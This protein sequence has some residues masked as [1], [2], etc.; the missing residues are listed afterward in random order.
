[1]DSVFVVHLTDVHLFAEPGGRLGD[2]DTDASLREVLDFLRQDLLQL[3]RQPD[4]ILMTGDLSQ[5]GS[6]QAYA[7]LKEAVLDFRAPLAVLPGNH[8]LHEAF[9]AEWREYEGPWV[10]LG[11]W[12]IVLLDTV[13]PGSDA[14]RLA[15]DQLSLL[16]DAAARS[17]GR[18]VLVA[19]HHNPVTDKL[20]GVDE[21]MLANAQALFS[22]VRRQENVRA[23]LWG[24]VHRPYDQWLMRDGGEPGETG[25]VEPVPD[26]DIRLLASPSTCLQ[27]RVRPGS[28]DDRPGYRLLDL[29]PDGGIRTLVRRVGDGAVGDWLS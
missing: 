18:H 14:G 1:M 20:D 28:G 10:N 8:D 24:H 7:R 13:V 26:R 3:G 2:V 22:T 9:H 5:D 21:L 15:P 12:R 11:D 4:L 23:L 25:G 29:L 6:P 27:F 16:A 19:L 17:E